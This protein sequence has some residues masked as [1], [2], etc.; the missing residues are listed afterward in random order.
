MCFVTACSKSNDN[1]MRHDRKKEAIA[2]LH[3]RQD[4]LVPTDLAQLQGSGAASF[5]SEVHDHNVRSLEILTDVAVNTL[6]KL[7]KETCF[8]PSEGK[9]EFDEENLEVTCFTP[10]TRSDY[11]ADIDFCLSLIKMP[12]SAIPQLE[13]RLGPKKSVHIRHLQD[14]LEATP[15][16]VISGGCGDGISKSSTAD[17]EELQLTRGTDGISKISTAHREELQ[18]TPGTDGISKISTAHREELQLTPGT[19]DFQAEREA[20]PHK[21]KKRG[22][23][24]DPSSI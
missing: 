1:N 9:L 8:G 6:E 13:K 20:F 24:E 18:L 5:L 10:E 19:G 15:Y 22:R 11:D 4:C 3:G 17:R 2:R 21:G 14:L 12:R 23:E 16:Q 7:E